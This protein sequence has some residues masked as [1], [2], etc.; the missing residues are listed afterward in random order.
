M[1][2]LMV[3]PYHAP[4][5]A[6]GGPVKVAETMAADF[7]AAGHEVTVATTDVLDERRRVPPAAPSLPPGATVHR[8]PNA[9]HALAVRASGY[10]PL[11][12]RAWLAGEVPRFDLLHLHDVYSALSVSASRAAGR[13]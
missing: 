7:L 4:A 5:Y 3:T 6:F 1:R 13:A 9:S 2:L 11:G 12:L 10:A 8:F